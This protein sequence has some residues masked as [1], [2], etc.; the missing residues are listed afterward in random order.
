M[1]RPGRRGAWT[2]ERDNLPK[3]TRNALTGFYGPAKDFFALIVRFLRSF[4]SDRERTIYEQTPLYMLPSLWYTSDME[5]T[6][7]CKTLLKDVQA[8]IREIQ[9]VQGFP[10]ANCCRCSHWWT[11]RTEAPK[12]CP[13]CRSRHWATERT[14]QQGVGS[15]EKR[16]AELESQQPITKS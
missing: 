6:G 8:K 7:H 9:F 10:V 1:W 5:R 15:W 2:G 16:L 4:C 11:K 12:K 3:T 13:K 14:N